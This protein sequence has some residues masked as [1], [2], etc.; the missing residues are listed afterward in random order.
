[1]DCMQILKSNQQFISMLK[2]ITRDLHGVDSLDRPGL[3][4]CWAESSFPFWNSLF[5]TNEISERSVLSLRLR[6][7]AEYMR[8]KSELGN[9]YL[10]SDNL[11]EELKGDLAMLAGEEGLCV[12]FLAAG[13][14]GPVPTRLPLPSALKF[15]PVLDNSGLAAFADVNSIA[16]GFSIASGEAGIAGSR[17][18]IDE[19]FSYVGYL[20]GQPVC[21]SAVTPNEGCLYVSLVATLPSMRKRGFASLV[22]Q[23]CLF[24]A[25]TATGISESFLHA[26]TEGVPVYERLGFEKTTSFV[27]LGLTQE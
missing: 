11:T 20:E 6:E 13:M 23:H 18:W 25:S 19:A 27:A 22:V 9:T 3:A 5:L 4:V 7:A 17:F 26:S 10:C 14:A 24:V 8:S 15:G 2:R 1:M 16:N 21:A 12:R